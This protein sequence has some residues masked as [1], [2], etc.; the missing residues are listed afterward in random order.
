MSPLLSVPCDY[1]GTNWPSL[2]K[3]HGSHA[4]ENT[5]WIAA[6]I[7]Q[8]TSS[9]TIYEELF[10]SSSSCSCWCLFIFL[11]VFCPV[12]TARVLMAEKSKYFLVLCSLLCSH[13]LYPQNF[14]IHFLTTV[15]LCKDVS[16][17]LKNKK[18]FY[19]TLFWCIFLLPIS[20]P[21]RLS[22]LCNLWHCTQLV[23]WSDHRQPRTKKCT[24][25]ARGPKHNPLL[26]GQKSTI[27]SWPWLNPVCLHALIIASD[28][29]FL[30]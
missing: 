10:H 22:Q 5:P 23:E 4:V 28:Y 9:Q 26:Q 2:L 16:I 3:A 20:S 6:Q 27:T 24:P 7:W 15:H 12:V 25:Q 11:M 18:L 19:N 21:M 17:P 14:S 30:R 8:N 13:I 1:M 29:L